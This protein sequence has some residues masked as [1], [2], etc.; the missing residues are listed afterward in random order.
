MFIL[1][2]F[3]CGKQIMIDNQYYRY[4]YVCQDIFLCDYCNGMLV[5]IKNDENLS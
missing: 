1:D 4:Y 2:N 3:Y 5:R